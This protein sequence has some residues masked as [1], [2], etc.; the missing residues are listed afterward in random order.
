MPRACGKVM[1]SETVDEDDDDTSGIR[2]GQT[3]PRCC[4]VEA[5]QLM[6]KDADGSGK[7][8]GY[9][10]KGHGPKLSG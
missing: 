4:R 3:L 2:Q 6:S 8:V 5:R 1:K 9:F 10:G 7:H